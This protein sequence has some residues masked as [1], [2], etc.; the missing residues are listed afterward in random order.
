[1]NA[2]KATHT[3]CNTTRSDTL[4]AYQIYVFKNT[5][6]PFVWH[7]FHA[8]SIATTVHCGN[9]YIHGKEVAPESG[10]AVFFALFV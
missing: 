3:K 9:F 2:N 1:M 5:M 7:I 8:L 6:I 4:R 10:R